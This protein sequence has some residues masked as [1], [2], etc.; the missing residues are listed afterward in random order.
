MIFVYKTNVYIIK[1]LYRNEA[2]SFNES[3]K[4]NQNKIALLVIEKS[5]FKK[6]VKKAMAYPSREAYRSLIFVGF[7]NNKAISQIHNELANAYGD[8]APSKRTIRRWLKDFKEGKENIKDLPHTGYSGNS[9]KYSK[10]GILQN[11]RKLV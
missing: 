9:R 11:L 3:F 7:K 6:H 4:K 5:E 1:K 2:L 8:K 10:R